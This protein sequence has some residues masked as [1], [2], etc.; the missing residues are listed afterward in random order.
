[1]SSGGTPPSVTLKDL[2]QNASLQPAQL[3]IKQ[4][5]FLKPTPPSTQ[6][7][8][9]SPQFWKP[10]SSFIPKTISL[11][12]Q[13]N[14][15]MRDSLVM[16]HCTLKSSKRDSPFKAAFYARYW[17][18]CRKEFSNYSS[19]SMIFKDFSQWILYFQSKPSLRE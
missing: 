6:F 11:Q 18:N 4:Q 12:P 5:Q 16:L 17:S 7:C 19:Q 10:S 14:P 15:F 1:M 8:S 13:Q 3:S 9:R 2:S